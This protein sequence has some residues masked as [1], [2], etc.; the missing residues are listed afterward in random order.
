[1]TSHPGNL[2]TTTPVTQDRDRAMYDWA[3]RHREILA[4]NREIKP[5][6]VFIGDSLI[7]YWSGEPKAPLEV[8]ADSWSKCFS[9]FTMTNLGFGWDRTENVLWRIEHGELDGID[10]KVIL[11]KIGTNNI[12]LNTP[13]EIAAGIAAIVEAAHI[14]QP[15]ANILLLGL[16]PRG[17]HGDTEKVNALLAQRWNGTKH[18]FFRNIGQ[19]LLH[20]DGTRDASL[21][22]DPVHIVA[23]GYDRIGP[24]IRNELLGIMAM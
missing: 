17:D 12:G 21:Y 2:T 5:D 10:P 9:G 22:K 16:L 20:A 6:L 23:A 7:H 8:H 11:I 3:Q 14:R 24:A 18:V 13:E 15:G 19:V 1:M 4:R